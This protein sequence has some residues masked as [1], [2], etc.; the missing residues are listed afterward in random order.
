MFRLSPIFTDFH[1]HFRMV[2]RAGGVKLLRKG[3]LI[4]GLAALVATAVSAQAQSAD[5][6]YC[7]V[8]V[9]VK[10]PNG[11]PLRGTSVM[12]TRSSESTTESEAVTD[13]AGS[14]R[15][16]DVPMDVPLDVYISR[17]ASCSVTINQV[18]PRWASPRHFTVIF[19]FCPYNSLNGLCDFILRVRDEEG[20]P[21][22]AAN[23]VVRDDGSSVVRSA[24]RSDDRGRIF[25]TARNQ[26][27]IDV[28]V[29][30]LGYTDEPIKLYCEERT[31]A[32]EMNVTLRREQK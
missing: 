21:I 18:I 7:A 2:S 3:L 4:C 27:I 12:V 14:A 23:L 16:C 30:K 20:K 32:K 13:S 11:E 5:R 29:R 6:P 22:S 1:E 8:E 31:F 17:G 10:K 26:R 15:I 9:T 24:Q 28:T 19:D 25:V